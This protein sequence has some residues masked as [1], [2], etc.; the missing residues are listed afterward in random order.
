MLIKIS[1]LIT[2]EIYEVLYR[3]GHLDELVIADANYMA[4]A[5]SK[6]VVYSYSQENHKLERTA[7]FRGNRRSE[8]RG[9][10]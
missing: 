2:P 6:K 9:A 7:D 3:M 1:D 4:S 10:L 5:M 8:E